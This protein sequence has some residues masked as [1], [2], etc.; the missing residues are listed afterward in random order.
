MVLNHKLVFD[1]VEKRT[2]L[3]IRYLFH[4]EPIKI[5]VKES[6]DGAYFFFPLVGQILHEGICFIVILYPV[7]Q[8][9]GV[10]TVA[11]SKFNA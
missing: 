1:L 2:P 6:R 4:F 5:A 3:K 11:S 9:A 7:Y 8:P 10:L